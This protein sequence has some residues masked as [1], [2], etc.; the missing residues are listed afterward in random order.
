MVRN[1]Q[2]IK[3]PGGSNHFEQLV[4][5]CLGLLFKPSGLICWHL[6]DSNWHWGDQALCGRLGR[7][8][9]GADQFKL[10]QQAKALATYFAMFYASI[11][12]GSMVSTIAV[13]FLRRV[14]C[15]SEET[16]FSPAFAFP[17]GLMLVALLLFWAGSWSYEVHIREEK[18]ISSFFKSS[19]H[20]FWSTKKGKK[21][22]RWLEC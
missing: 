14:T 17:S 21:E 3:N 7:L 12:M 22:Q 4:G 6:P 8:Q 20:A 10:P 19:W 5:K 15:F 13:P 18:V 9:M 11:N 1:I 2:E 16:C